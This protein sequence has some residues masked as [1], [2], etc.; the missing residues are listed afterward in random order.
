M[1][2][3]YDVV[4]ETAVGNRSGTM[5]VYIDCNLISGV[6]HILKHSEPFAGKVDHAGKC[7]IKG[8]LSTLM[9]RIPYF[10]VGTITDQVDLEL[11]CGKETFR[12][13]GKRCV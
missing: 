9:R 1:K 6:L 12:L 11:N 2:N 13:V 10:A 7:R 3:V 8:N 4:L 5:D